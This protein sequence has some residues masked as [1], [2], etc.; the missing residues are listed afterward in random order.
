MHSFT[1]ALPKVPVFDTG[2]LLG[3]S[4]NSALQNGAYKGII[5]EIEGFVERIKLKYGRINT[6][7]T[8]GDSDFLA[9]NLKT[10]IFVVRNLVLRGLLE[11]LKHNEKLE[12]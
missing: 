9:K 8:G 10:K 6:I 7:L 12:E 1:A 4:T 3:T 5:C 2:K 11:I